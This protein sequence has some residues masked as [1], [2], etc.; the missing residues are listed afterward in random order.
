MHQTPLKGVTARQRAETLE[1]KG[2]EKIVKYDKE[3][4]I[5]AWDYLILL[6]SSSSDGDDNYFYLGGG[7]GGGRFFAAK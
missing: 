1:R 5:R 6:A 2:K 4:F 3:G 7:G